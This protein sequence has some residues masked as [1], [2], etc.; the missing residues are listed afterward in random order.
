MIFDTESNYLC[1]F[2]FLGSKI[3]SDC[4]ND[5]VPLFT[6]LNEELMFGLVN[7][8]E[9]SDFI[10]NSRLERDRVRFVQESASLDVYDKGIGTSGNYIY[11][12]NP[13]KVDDAIND[14]VTCI[15]E[16]YDELSKGL[17]K[18]CVNIDMIFNCISKAN[19]YLTWG[20][21][22]GFGPHYDN[23]DVIVFQLFGSKT[24]SLWSSEGDGDGDGRCYGDVSK[25]DIKSEVKLNTGDVL[26]I[27]QGH[28]HN[29][30]C[31]QSNSLHVTISVGHYSV[32]DYLGWVVREL[33]DH[34]GGDI[35]DIKLSDINEDQLT[36]V[37][38]DR[39]NHILKEKSR[40]KKFLSDKSDEKTRTKKVNDFHRN[41]VLNKI[42]NL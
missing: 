14:G 15:I 23:H 31:N 24:W 1:V 7:K 19:L 2:D 3:L 28:W 20:S 33:K 34:I 26:Y 36:S 40:F 39:I 9:V 6:H 27:P 29:P 41:S 21:K 37:I 11:K 17:N 4:I 22:E 18:V 32:N 12:V 42:N 30:V 8:R 16:A 38:R 13:K 25:K 10:F 5:G 35:C